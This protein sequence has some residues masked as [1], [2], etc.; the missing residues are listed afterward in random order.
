[1]E[2]GAFVTVSTRNVIFAWD[3]GW[4]VGLGS[5]LILVGLESIRG[6]QAG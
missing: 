5:L 2:C 3:G 1:M 6:K 4:W